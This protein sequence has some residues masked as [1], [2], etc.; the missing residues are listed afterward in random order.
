MSR[1]PDLRFQPGRRMGGGMAPRPSKSANKGA[2]GE[3]EKED[4]LKAIRGRSASRSSSRQAPA[5]S[6]G[7]SAPAS[8][9]TA[10]REPV[11]AGR[12]RAPKRRPVRMPP[13]IAILEAVSLA[14]GQTP[15]PPPADEEPLDPAIVKMIE[16][17]LVALAS[18]NSAWAE[19]LGMPVSDLVKVAGL[20]QSLVDRRQFEPAALQCDTL[21]R[22]LPVVPVF[23]LGLGDLREELGSPPQALEAYEKCISAADSLDPAA[24]EGVDARLH[25]SAILV[26][27]GQP[28]EAAGDLVQVLKSERDGRGERAM[29]AAMS[30]RKMLAQ[31]E[32]QPDSLAAPGEVIGAGWKV[33]NGSLVYQGAV[34]AASNARYFATPQSGLG[35]RFGASRYRGSHGGQA[36]SSS[37]PAFAR[38]T[39]EGAVRKGTREGR[40]AG[41]EG[42]IIS[43]Q[44]HSFHAALRSRSYAGVLS[45]VADRLEALTTRGELE[46]VQRRQL[47]EQ[48]L[49]LLEGMKAFYKQRAAGGRSGARG[50]GHAMA[51]QPG[52]FRGAM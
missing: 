21:C 51:A 19:V 43:K 10:S 8:T 28:A 7:K 46:D 16:Q 48:A 52:R 34:A 47:R 22:L 39:F 32:V 42:W 2:E 37:R 11:G 36:A 49:P 18:G 25:R 14:A 4:Q 38:A 24:D 29:A 44:R 13:R 6:G 1:G 3:K 40:L 12:A 15:P 50:R 5:S 17:D 35:G 31:G 45:R 33:E 20:S 26:A 23:W 9:T 27:Q 30:L 41:A